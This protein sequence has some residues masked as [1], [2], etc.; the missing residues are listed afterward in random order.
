M[1][2]A[3]NRYYPDVSFDLT[4]KSMARLAC[5]QGIGR[6]TTDPLSKNA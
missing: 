1:Q 6:K 3:F 2:G 4:S 5:R